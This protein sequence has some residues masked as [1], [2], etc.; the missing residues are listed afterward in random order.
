MAKEYT[1]VA[2]VQLTI[3]TGDIPEDVI[4]SKERLTEDLKKELIGFSGFDDAL[5]K[6]IKVFE[7]DKETTEE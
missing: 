1:I 3:I 2:D 7:M 6:G 4:V 5:V